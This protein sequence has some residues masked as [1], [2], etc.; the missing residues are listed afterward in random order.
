MIVQ[1]LISVAILGF[2]D[3]TLPDITRGAIC[4]TSLTDFLADPPTAFYS[5]HPCAR[6]PRGTG[7][8][9]R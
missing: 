9:A 3:G 1:L 2:R 5:L 7:T 8:R 4:A 6:H